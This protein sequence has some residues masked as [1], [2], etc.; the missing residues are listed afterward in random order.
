MSAELFLN[1]PLFND[2]KTLIDWTHFRDL[3]AIE[4]PLKR[5][6]YTRMAELEGWSTRTL[7]ERIDSML[8]ERSLL[9]KKPEETIRLELQA[10]AE[11]ENKDECRC[12][13]SRFSTGHHRPDDRRRLD[14]RRPRQ[15]QSRA[16]TLHT[17][18]H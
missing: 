4:N 15:L 3:I 16:G 12:Q 13:R 5:D 6:F 7:R 18:L 9:S 14:A 8:F 2:V 10:L 17:G 1:T 11:K